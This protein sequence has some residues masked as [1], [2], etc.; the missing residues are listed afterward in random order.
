MRDTGGT[1]AQVTTLDGHRARPGTDPQ[2]LPDGE[3][4]VFT[5]LGHRTEIRAAR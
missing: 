1:P 5:A 2:F 4:F 3:R